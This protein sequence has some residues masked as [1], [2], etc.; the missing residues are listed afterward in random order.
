MKIKVSALKMVS[1]RLLIYLENRGH[2]TIELNEDFY[3]NISEE[4]KYIMETSPVELEIGQLSE[5]WA[6]LMTAIEKERETLRYEFI[7]FAK[8]LEVIGE[9]VV[10]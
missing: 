8:I 4:E 1:D 3:W 7:W 9:K 10:H 2:E 6:F 5:D